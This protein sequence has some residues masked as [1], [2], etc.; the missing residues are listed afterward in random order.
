MGMSR[1]ERMANWRE[2]ELVDRIERELV[3]A[4][5]PRNV[6]EL[7]TASGWLAD[8]VEFELVPGGDARF[9]TDAQERTGWVEAALA[10]DDDGGGGHLV[11]WWA[12]EG[13]S[14]TRVEITL[15]PESAGMT[16]LRVLETRPLQVLDLVGIP[17]PGTGGSTPGPVMLS[18]A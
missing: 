16:R 5:P 6:W 14:A 9:L 4:A 13:D 8:E 7:V 12:A 10:P 18:L 1:D 15:E 3:L 11:F 17:L 2:E